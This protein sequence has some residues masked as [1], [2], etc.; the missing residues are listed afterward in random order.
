MQ[1][2]VF[3][4]E[5]GVDSALIIGLELLGQTDGSS[6]FKAEKDRYHLYV[7]LACPWAHRALIVCKLKGL[8]EVLPYT[9]VDWLLGE[10]G[11]SFTDQA[12]IEF[13]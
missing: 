13:I 5:Q 4:T 8:E 9:V 7:S 11:W 10:N 12:I 2:T 1:G 6:G 3:L